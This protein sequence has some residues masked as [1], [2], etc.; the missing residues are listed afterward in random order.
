GSGRRALRSD[1]LCEPLLL[2]ASRERRGIRRPAA[3]RF[4]QKRKWSGSSRPAAPGES[5]GPISSAHLALAIISGGS[6]MQ[7]NDNRRSPLRIRFIPHVLRTLLE[8]GARQFVHKF[9]VEIGT[10]DQ[11]QIDADR[12]HRTVLSRVSPLRNQRSALQREVQPQTITFGPFDDSH[13]SAD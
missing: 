3:W 7:W 8:V 5:S 4:P 10:A 2:A 6:R 9:A 11:T 12:M 13:S 1:A